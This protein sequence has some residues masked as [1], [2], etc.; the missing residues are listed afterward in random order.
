[1]KMT[2]A[3]VAVLALAACSKETAAPAGDASATT[4][5]AN[6]AFAASLPLAEQQGFEDAKRGLIARPEGKIL[7]AD[8]SVLVDFDAFKFVAGDA[9]PTVNPSLWRHAKLNAQAG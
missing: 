6:A 7:A 1:M 4:V 8:G 5:Q 9:P 2:L 3:F